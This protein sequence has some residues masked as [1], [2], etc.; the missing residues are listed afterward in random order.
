M[1]VELLEPLSDSRVRVILD[2]DVDLYELLIASNM[3]VT[4]YSTVFL[5]C[6]S[7]EVPNVIVKCP[8]Y[9]VA[10]ELVDRQDLLVAGTPQE[11]VALVR[12][13]AGSSGYRD[14][15]IREEGDLQEIFLR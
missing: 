2:K 4:V 11:L 9:E 13:L 7:L 8:G 12:K 15:V 3:H 6:L 5:E 10:F 1:A 14:E